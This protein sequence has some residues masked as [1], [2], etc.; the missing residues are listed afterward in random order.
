M[1]YTSIIFLYFFLPSFMAIYALVKASWRP[2]I[3]AAGSC[4]VTLWVSPFALIPM[5]VS[6]AASYLA[7]IS[8]G[9]LRLKDNKKAAGAVL[10]LFLLIISA[11]AVYFFGLSKNDDRLISAVGLGIMTVGAVSYCF[12]IYR[13]ETEHETNPFKVWAYVCFLPSLCGIPFVRYAE[14]KKNLDKPEIRSDLMADGILMMLTGICEKVIVSDRLY[15]LF[16]DMHSSSS[17]G[18]SS[19]MYWV[20]AVIFGA[21]LYIKLKGLSHIARGFAMMLGFEIPPSFDFPYSKP[22][23]KEYIQSYNIPGCGFAHRYIYEPLT[24]KIKSKGFGIFAA[25]ITVIILCISYSITMN[26]LLWG[27]FASLILM[28]ELGFEKKLSAIPKAVRYIFTHTFIIIGWALISQDSTEAALDY[29]MHM[30][31]GG[32]MIDSKPLLYFLG[33]AAPYFLLMLIFELPVIYRA[34]QKHRKRG[35]SVIAAAKPFLIFALLILC[36]S[37]MMAGG[38]QTE[39]VIR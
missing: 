21:A 9:R 6:V 26:Y 32:M 16:N 8:L 33:T 22:T 13:G 24:E 2:F 35:S 31:T 5:L 17:G 36:T 15:Q 23:L 20:G 38:L 19:I 39:G 28:L 18:L 29:I 30:F 37:F 1:S 10:L 3:M 7:G 34:I 4:F 27:V 25:A 14:L 12:D 11:Q